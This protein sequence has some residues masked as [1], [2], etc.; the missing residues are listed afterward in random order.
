MKNTK[1]TFKLSNISLPTPKIW[2]RIG[3]TLLA[4]SV[5]V[6]GFSLYQGEKWISIISFGS[7]VLGTILTN[8]VTEETI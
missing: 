5:F 8:M 3:N 7:G 6:G 2:K 1:K 4:V